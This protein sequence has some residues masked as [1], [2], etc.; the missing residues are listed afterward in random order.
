MRDLGSN[1]NYIYT[2]VD[3]LLFLSAGLSKLSFAKDIDPSVNGMGEPLCP[4]VNHNGGCTPLLWFNH[5]G[6]NT[7]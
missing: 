3:T 7:C 6:Y 5:C 4:V 1:F 2:R